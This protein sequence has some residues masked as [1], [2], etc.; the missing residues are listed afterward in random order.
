[1]ISLLLLLSWWFGQSS[2][3]KGLDPIEAANEDRDAA[4]KE[5]VGA[6]RAWVEMGAMYERAMGTNLVLRDELTKASKDLPWLE[7]RNFELAEENI[8]QHNEIEDL[9][10]FKQKHEEL[11]S[12]VHL[13]GMSAK[14]PEYYEQQSDR[15]QREVELQTNILDRSQ[16]C[17]GA[18]RE[19]LDAERIKTEKEKKW[20]QA[21]LTKNSRSPAYWAKHRLN[22]YTPDPKPAWGVRCACT[23]PERAYSLKDQS[24]RIVELEATVA[25]RDL[26]IARLRESRLGSRLGNVS[27]NGSSTSNAVKSSL[28]STEN[29]ENGSSTGSQAASN[30]TTV[31]A[32][33]IDAKDTV[34]KDLREEL[35]AGHE[36]VNDL[37]KQVKDF[38]DEQVTAGEELDAKFEE[39]KNLRE[40][41][42]TEISNLR[43]ELSE[44]RKDLSDAREVG[45]ERERQLGQRTTRVKELDESIEQKN[46]EIVELE[47]AMLELAEQPAPESA[48]S[49]RRL[50]TANTNLEKL[51]REH[52]ECAG[53]LETQNARI[54]ELE[55]HNEANNEAHNET[56][57]EA[58]SKKNREYQALYN[59][60][61]KVLGQQTTME[62]KHNEDMQLLNTMQQSEGMMQLELQRLQ[63]DYN[64]FRLL[65]TNCDGHVTD[66]TNRLRQGANTYTD[67][68]TQY[69]TQATELDEAKQEVNKLTSEMNALQ[70]RKTSLEQMDSSS[71]STFEKYRVEGEDRVRPNWQAYL[72]R[73]MSASALKLEESER[74]VFK[75]ESL[76]Q[77]A[78]NENSPLRVKQLEDREE[79]VKA[80]EDELKL[81]TDAM[82]HDQQ[83]RKADPE[84]K[85]LEK[86][87]TAAN[88]EAGDAKLRNRGIQNQLNKERK[89]R[90]DEEMRHEKELK[91]EREDSNKRT[92]VLK[93]S[94][95]KENPLKNAVSLLQ[96]QVADLTKKLEAKK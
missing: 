25:A 11:L 28:P 1:M 81:T 92:E 30:Y 52:A 55:A 57:R 84:V 85:E 75:L 70:E 73:E 49:L 41:K 36:K 63:T 50:T 86:K 35:I 17:V 77:Q 40:E 59:L 29:P 68:Q 33:E 8:V 82:D 69:N 80:K 67:L 72:D 93:I 9:K 66:L 26:T 88:K 76:L 56:H 53:R 15:L 95:E 38:E 78:K 48:E 71:E 13:Y 2:F 90:K 22:S 96:N 87:L 45:A 43:H 60:Y 37:Q 58:I 46:S 31:G 5:F 42:T 44:S 7:Q 74:K 94:L 64:T 19:T 6:Q 79:A 14:R 3:E 91:K 39:I 10:I 12:E 23:E 27:K 61:E 24:P 16:M 51:R 21:R 54:S 4:V 83:G 20:L 89:E 34:I 62:T 18:L 32:E 65:H 47:R